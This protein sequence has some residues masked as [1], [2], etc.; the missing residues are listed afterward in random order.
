MF[1]N[2]ILRPLFVEHPWL[3]RVCQWRHERRLKPV[4]PEAGGAAPPTYGSPASDTRS[5]PQPPRCQAPP[6]G[7]G[8]APAGRHPPPARGL[9]RDPCS[10]LLNTALPYYTAPQYSPAILH[11]SSIHTY[12]RHW[13]LTQLAFKRLCMFGRPLLFTGSKG[14]FGRDFSEVSEWRDM[15][16]WRSLDKFS[17]DIAYW[18]SLNFMK[19]CK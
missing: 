18:R 16:I 7:C 1:Y 8:G 17:T 10:P 14:N 15:V 4:C 3:H 5:Q 11:S 12:T 9:P 2:Y 6:E 13:E 19:V